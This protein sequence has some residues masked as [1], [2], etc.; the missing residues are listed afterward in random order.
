MLNYSCARHCTVQSCLQNCFGDAGEN[1]ICIE[2]PALK[3][4]I[5]LELT[6]SVDSK[7]KVAT[8]LVQPFFFVMLGHS[9]PRP[10]SRPKYIVLGYFI[11]LSTYPSIQKHV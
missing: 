11:A 8:C 10:K 7:N 6:E 1:P 2:G 9:D 5:F 4:T 3:L